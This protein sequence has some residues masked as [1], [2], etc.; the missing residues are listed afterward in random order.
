MTTGGLQGGYRTGLLASRGLLGGG[1]DH[2]AHARD[3]AV[4]DLAAVDVERR[5]PTD[6]CRGSLA[7]VGVHHLVVLLG[8]R[9]EV[10]LESLDVAAGVRGVFLE[11]SAVELAGRLHPAPSVGGSPRDAAL[12]WLEREEDLD[13]GW[14]AAP[15]GWMDASGAGEFCVA[16]RSALVRD[17]E[18]V[19][20]AG[21]GIVEG[22]DPESEL[23]ETRLKLRVLL[24]PLL[25]I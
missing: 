5:G 7:V 9:L 15:L 21:A 1:L 4:T 12:A 8:V 13:R 10:L 11:L 16:L 3:A 20:F 14:Y 2:G 22:S 18:A 25:E 6:V 17:R 19:L 24:G 23:L